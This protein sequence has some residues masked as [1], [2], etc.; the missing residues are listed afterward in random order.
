MT[1]L[2]LGERRGSGRTSKEEAPHDPDDQ[3]LRRQAAVI[4][5]QLPDDH[6]SALIVLAWAAEIIRFVKAAPPIT[7]A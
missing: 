7:P 1:V 5:S 3:W 6:R 4:V 2:D